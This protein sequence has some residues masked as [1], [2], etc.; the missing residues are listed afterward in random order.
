MSSVRNEQI[1][2]AP[3]LYMNGLRMSY[4]SATTINVQEGAARDSTNSVDISL[5]DGAQLNTAINGLNGLDTGTIAASTLYTLY[6]ISDV[7]VNPLN[8]TGVIASLSQIQPLYPFG[9]SNF[10][11]IGFFKTDGSANI[12]PFIMECFDGNNSPSRYMQY[13]VNISVLSSGSATTYASVDLSAALPLLGFGRADIFTTLVPSAAG[14]QLF[15]RPGGATG[16]MF[17]MT[18]Q[19]T[20]VN[21]NNAFGILPNVPGVVPAIDYKVTNGSD[22]ASISV[23]GYTMCL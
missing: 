21:L 9:Y 1:T 23:T 16:D 15:V 5:V 8:Q 17:V 4:N 12:I 13:L 10:R 14:R 6:V 3:S 7:T 2:N 18:G 22:V 11:K 19:V 20:S